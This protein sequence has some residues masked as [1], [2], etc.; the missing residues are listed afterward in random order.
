VQTLTP[1]FDFPPPH[2]LITV[3][4][5]GGSEEDLRVFGET[6]NAKVKWRENF[7]SPDKNWPNFGGFGGLEIRWY[8]KFRFLLL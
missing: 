2:C 4:L 3:I 8:K 1:Y 5:L 7:L 6:A